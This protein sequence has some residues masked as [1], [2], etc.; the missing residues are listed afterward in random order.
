MPG[1]MNLKTENP[2]AQ[3]SK[4]ERILQLQEKIK[5]EE[6]A[7]AE[8]KEHAENLR[9]AYEAQENQKEL[10]VFSQ[11][12][13]DAK[14]EEIAQRESNE[15]TENLQTREAILKLLQELSADDKEVIK[16]ELKKHEKGDPIASLK[17]TLSDW[18]FGKSGDSKRE[19]SLR[20]LL[21]VLVAGGLF[22]GV[23]KYT[24]T[25]DTSQAPQKPVPENPI[26]AKPSVPQE[27]AEQKAA[28]LEEEAFSKIGEDIAE[29]MDLDLFDSLSTAGKM[30]YIDRFASKKNYLITNKSK[31]QQFLIRA[32]NQLLIKDTVVTGQVRGDAPNLVT[33]K[34]HPELYGTTPAGYYTIGKEDITEK[35]KKEF[36]ENA[37]RI[38]T[39]YPANIFLHDMLNEERR[40][41]MRKGNYRQ[42]WGCINEA[43][44][45]TMNPYLEEG[46]FIAI[47]P[48]STQ[49][50]ETVIDPETGEIVPKEA[51]HGK[52]MRVLTYVEKFA[53]IQR[54]K[55]KKS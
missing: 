12:L 52:T 2:P 1:D 22:Y 25:E 51:Y 19:K 37:W 32:D 27:S 29:K 43:H 36:G 28:R 44:L 48:D 30:V 23:I 10:S 8:A 41:K 15:G 5:K 47:L 31:G 7:L 24:N 4:A 55:V 46:T 9:R 18:F 42:S 21:W 26:P 49:G 34:N 39:D 35:D 54:N 20:K 38:Y 11:S 3:L 16:G 40:D 6:A 45:S 13:Y 50:K 53:I 14:A 33:E 17:N